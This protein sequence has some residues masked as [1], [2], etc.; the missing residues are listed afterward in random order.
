MTAPWRTVPGKGRDGLDYF[1]HQ[2]DGTRFGGWYRPL[3]EGCIEV[4]AVGL[5]RTLELQGRPPQVVACQ[6]LEEFVRLR[7]QLGLPLP[8]FQDLESGMPTIL[9]GQLERIEA[10]TG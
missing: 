5:I 10:G 1:T 3:S 7:Q 2:V 9:G 6:A 4:L 8:E